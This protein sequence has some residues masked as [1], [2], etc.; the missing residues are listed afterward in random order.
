MANP[1]DTTLRA[2]AA[3]VR[4][5]AFDLAR[6]LAML[7]MVMVHVQTTYG[8][9]E[10]QDSPFGWMVEFLGSPPA[11]PVFMFLMGLSTAFSSRATLTRGVRRGIEIF[12][13]GYALNFLRGSLPVLLALKFGFVTREELGAETALTQFLNVDILQFAGIALVVMALC[14]R[15]L[16]K[17]SAW[18]GVAAVVM[19][20][21]PLM[22]GRT[23]DQ[24]LVRCL[25]NH[26]WGAEGE[27]VAFP[28]FPWLCYPLIGMACGHWLIEANEGGR[29]FA[30]SLIAGLTLLAVGTGITLSNPDFHIGDYY[31]SGPGAVLWIQGF[32][33]VWVWGCRAVTNRVPP[34]P[35]FRLL[36]FWS[37][38]VTAFYFIHWIVIGWGVLIF[39]YRERGLAAT[40]LLMGVVALVADRCTRLWARFRYPTP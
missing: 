34:N 30:R 20:V 23:T 35:A 32:V 21:S 25:L 27:R 1:D 24:P 36:Y 28:A 31:R 8:A 38:R 19:L 26:L 6:G 13:L 39:G 15:F 22:W 3:A 29:F 7:F 5:E 10:V 16:P 33:L 37:R 11:A 9:T 2:G 4:V 40:V 17:P 12:A 14:R 18:I